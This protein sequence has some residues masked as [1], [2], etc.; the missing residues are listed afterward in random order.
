MSRIAGREQLFYLKATWLHSGS[1]LEKST[2]AT[3]WPVL[4]TLHQV[5]TT[6]NDDDRVMMAWFCQRVSSLFA[7][8]AAVAVLAWSLTEIDP[9]MLYTALS[10][11]VAWSL[12]IMEPN[13]LERAS[14][15]LEELEGWCEEMD[16]LLA[17]G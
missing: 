12:L 7:C 1:L 10:A 16:R 3:Y 5:N 17:A 15:A 8:V 2:R 6:A 13:V 4:S 9:L 14:R 11:A